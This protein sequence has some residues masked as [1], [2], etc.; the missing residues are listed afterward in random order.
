MYSQKNR[1]KSIALLNKI[2]NDPGGMTIL[3]GFLFCRCPSILQMEIYVMTILR[4][5]YWNFMV[6]MTKNEDEN[7]K[8][9][10]KQREK[11]SKK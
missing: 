7:W 9:T 10:T 6:E 2:S 11:M 4:G 3:P 8:Y 1:K 5:K